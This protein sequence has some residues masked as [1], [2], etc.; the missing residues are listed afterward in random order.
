MTR[1]NQKSIALLLALALA[2]ALGAGLAS[3]AQAATTTLRVTL[4]ASGNLYADIQ[5]EIVAFDAIPGNNAAQTITHL[6]ID[7]NGLTMT[8]DAFTADSDWN[9]LAYINNTIS[10]Q[11]TGI[12]TPTSLPYLRTLTIEDLTTL[13]G[14]AMTPVSSS[15]TLHGPTWLENLILP[16]TLR[17]DALALQFCRNLKTVSLPVATHVGTRAFYQCDDLVSVSFPK[18]QEIGSGA[19]EI[20][21]NLSTYQCS[22][23]EVVFP[24][25]LTTMGDMIF[26]NNT[27]MTK[28]TFEGIVPPNISGSTGIF[29]DVNAVLR[30][31]IAVTVPVGYE[32]V[33]GVRL[34]PDHL[35][36]L[37]QI[38]N[39]ALT[40]GST[41]ATYSVTQAPSSAN[42][43]M[44]V[45]NAPHNTLTS[46]VVDGV[47]L[48]A[49]THY[50]AYTYGTDS[51]AVMLLSSYVSTLT[52]GSHTMTVYFTGGTS[53]TSF[54]V[55]TSDSVNPV[56][57]DSTSTAPP[58]VV[59]INDDGSQYADFLEQ[60]VE[61]QVIEIED[62][63]V[64]ES[65]EEMEVVEDDD[66]I[67][68]DPDLDLDGD[69]GGD[70]GDDG[71]PYEPD[72][73][74][75]VE[76]K[77]SYTPTRTATPLTG[78][79]VVLA[80]LAVSAVLLMRKRRQQAAARNDRF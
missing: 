9:A 59:V 51:T 55:A 14:N 36:S 27:S 17:L 78:V 22:L 80:A 58:A 47:T 30:R 38:N 77:P 19:F 4:T 31:T 12:S 48:T 57:V 2:L 26:A 1:R 3:P 13:P 69:D 54:T 15:G 6:I 29:Y 49:G 35:A 65:T 5:A 64:S 7:T 61:D 63:N 73:N 75:N 53:A 21:T 41:G 18:L 8:G 72:D 76:E 67:L 20:N 74:L 71:I 40:P 42:G 10:P 43:Y 39:G 23:K 34:Y 24:A 70:D 62:Y 60:V 56:I 28:V 66:D 33:Y 79:M 52:A 25:S 44:A 32:E 45:F 16:N 68:Y 37:S 50:N 11:P 46:V